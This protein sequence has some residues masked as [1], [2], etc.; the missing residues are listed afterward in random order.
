MTQK[1]WRR[2]TC[3]IHVSHKIGYKY[4][5]EMDCHVCQRFHEPAV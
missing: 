2:E 3:E 1:T 5:F 4:A